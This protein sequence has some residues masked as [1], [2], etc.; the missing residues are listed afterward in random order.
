M[1][2]QAWDSSS[3]KA[4]QSVLR[5]GFDRFLWGNYVLTNHSALTQRKG[6]F[7][8]RCLCI[9]LRTISGMHCKDKIPKFRNKY[10]K[11][12]NIGVSVPISTFMRLW[13]IDIFPQSVCLFC[14]RKYVDRSWEYINC[15]Q[16]HECGNWG[17]GRD[18]P[19]KGI[20]PL[21]SACSTCQRE[22]V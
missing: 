13:V 12:R 11:K 16:T 10:S 22:K 7:I 14:W 17:W 8:L 9:L 1:N 2:T 20:V 5:V 21:T 4:I 3:T 6:N 18:I 15:S 19:R